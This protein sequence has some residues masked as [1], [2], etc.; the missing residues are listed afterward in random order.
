MYSAMTVAEYVINKCTSDGYPISNM[1]LQNILYYIQGTFLKNGMT[2]FHDET[3]AWQFGPVVR[4]VYNKYC[5]FGSL[6]IRMNY[7]VIIR[8]EH[9]EVIDGIVEAKRILAPWDIAEDINAPG[10]AWDLTYRNGLG[11]HAVI[12]KDSIRTKG[13]CQNRIRDGV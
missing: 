13:F 1:R 9:A 5:G 6:K 11:N 4:D 10:N 3:E 12:P 8:N 7:D 2:A